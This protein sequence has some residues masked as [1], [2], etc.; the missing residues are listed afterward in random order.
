MEYL[1][2]WSVV[3]AWETGVLRQMQTT[4]A[5]L[6]VKFQRKVLYQGHLCDIWIR[7]S[8]FWWAGAKNE[9]WLTRDQYSEP[10]LRMSYDYQETSTTEPLLYWDNGDWWARAE[11]LVMEEETSI[12]GV[13]W[14][15][16]L[17]AKHMDSVVQGDQACSSGW[18]LN[19]VMYKRFPSG[20]GF[21][22]ME[23]SHGEQ[24]DLGT[25]WQG[26]DPWR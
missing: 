17:K 7:S 3:E 19:L 1:I 18:Q 12:T 25:R 13:F 23:R 4:E 21:E 14:E 5:W 2:Q 22:S 6:V 26:Q 20:T 9:L 10:L 8:W 15:Y 16:F 11:K 24:L